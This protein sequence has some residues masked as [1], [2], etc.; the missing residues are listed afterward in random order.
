[1]NPGK[2]EDQKINL[3]EQDISTK[4][5]VPAIQKSGWDIMTQVSEQESITDGRIIVSGKTIKRGKIKKPDFILSYQKNFPIAVIEVKDNNHSIASGIGQA[6]GYAKILDTPFAYSTNGDGFL[7]HDFLTGKEREL[8]IEEFPTR[9]ELYLRYKKAKNISDTS[10]KVIKYPYYQGNSK[11]TPRYYQQVAINRTIKAVAE[12]QK[13]ILLVM[14]TGTGKTFTAGQIIWRLWKSGDKKR[15]LFLADRNILVDQTM[16]NDFKH[17][18][19]K[20][21]K[22]SRKEVDKAY[23]IYLGLYQSLTGNEE[24]KNIYKQFS[25]DFFD[26]IIIDECHRGSARENS[27]WREILEYFSSATQVGLTATPKETSD[28]SNI[29]YFGEPIYTYS[30]KQGIEDGFL[31]PYK[32]IRVML[33]K[34]IGG[35]RPSISDRDRNGNPI[36]DKLYGSKDYDR[37]IVLTKRTKIV[38]REI[39]R[40]LKETDRFSKAIVFCVDIEHAQRMRKEL[41]NE[42]SDLVQENHKYIMQITGD[43]DEG[44]RELDNFIHPEEPYPTIVTTSKLLT[45]G[46]DA[47]TCKLIVLDANIN[48]MTEFKQIIGRGTRIREDVGKTHFTILDFRRATDQFADPNFDGDPVQIKEVKQGEELTTLE[49]AEEITEDLENDTKN[50]EEHNAKILTNDEISN[51]YSDKKFGKVEKIYI[52]NVEVN[53]AFKQTQ[54]LDQNGRLITGSFK[55]FSKNKILEIYKSLDDF[56][57]KWNLEE[58][59]TKIIEELEKQGINLEELRTNMGDI[60]KELDYFDLILHIAFGRKKLTTRKER[61]KNIRNSNYLSKYSQKAQKVLESLLDKYADQGLEHIE[62]I[63]VLTVKPFNKIGA[64]MEIIADFGGKSN[65]LLAIRDLENQIYMQE[66]RI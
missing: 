15:V 37:E 62:D 34:D 3:S 9:E 1:M 35:Y 14:A 17:F 63:K 52:D 6:I 16:V 41:I 59:K 10:E 11:K 23:E 19:D 56:I 22:I 50:K 21:T 33:D 40:F 47:Q 28:I 8:S 7:E 49:Q 65:Y 46:V 55:D 48:S 25:K 5:I 2:K 39:T 42:N 12:E 13:R 24:E 53:I 27:N 57:N 20:M 4:Y 29:G 60:A 64:P 54:I 31:A 51:Y 26:L 45:T 38:A 66:S 61:V 18:G 32:V 58:K 36:E 44:K 30:L 43:N